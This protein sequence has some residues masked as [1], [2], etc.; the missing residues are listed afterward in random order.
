MGDEKKAERDKMVSGEVYNPNDPELVQDRT[1]CRA[2]LRQ[3]NYTLDYT[4]KEKRLQ[5]LEGLLGSMDRE[6]PPWFE[7]PFYCDYG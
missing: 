2:S 1:A 3:L 4:E 6:Y 5:I 7:P